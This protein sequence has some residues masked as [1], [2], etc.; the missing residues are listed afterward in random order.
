[1]L[2]EFLDLFGAA[3]LNFAAGYYVVHRELLPDL[4]GDPEGL[5]VR[6]RLWSVEITEYNSRKDEGNDAN[7]AQ[8]AR[9]EK[10]RPHEELV[11]YPEHRS[12]LKNELSAAVQEKN[13]TSG[14]LK[15]I[16][17]RRQKVFLLPRLT[18]KEN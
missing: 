13:Q 17:A 18:L 3:P 14:F 15:D 16:V 9:T 6:L 2:C 5:I 1:M 8:G 12:E 11:S 4:S 10:V 7:D